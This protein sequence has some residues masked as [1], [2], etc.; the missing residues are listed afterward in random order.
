M[1]KPYSHGD[2]NSRAI[3]AGRGNS[4]LGHSSEPPVKDFD[5]ARKQLTE[6]SRGLREDEQK[7]LANVDINAARPSA[8]KDI[9]MDGSHIGRSHDSR[10]MLSA[11][12]L[13]SS[14]YDMD[15][16]E[17]MDD[18]DPADNIQLFEKEDDKHIK[19]LKVLHAK[20]QAEIRDLRSQVMHIEC[21][22]VI[23]S[24][25]GD[26]LREEGPESV[27]DE[28]DVEPPVDQLIP[29]EN[30]EKET[31][32]LEMD[33]ISQALQA[34]SPPRINTPPIERLPFLTNPPPPFSEI[35]ILQVNAD[36]HQSLKD[37]IQ[38]RIVEQ[39][40]KLAH[41]ESEIM[42]WYQKTYTLWRQNCDKLDQHSK[43]ALP[44][45]TETTRGAELSEAAAL[46]LPID[47]RRGGKFQSELDFQRALRESELDAIE[48]QRKKEQANQE[49]L[50]LAKEAI[51]PPMLNQIQRKA[52]IFQDISNLVPIDDVPGVFEYN[53]PF[54]QFTEEEQEIFTKAYMYDPKRFGAIAEKL[55][56][57]TYPE[58]IRHYYSTKDQER[59]KQKLSKRG[60]RKK[61]RRTVGQGRAK[62][63]N[64][65]MA[66]MRGQGEFDNEEENP[67][68]P[69]TDTGRPKRAAAPVFGD[70]P[71]ETDASAVAQGRRNLSAVRNDHT[72]DTPPERVAKRS[73]TTSTREKSQKRARNPPL[74]AAP[75]PSP[76]KVE[77][78]TEPEPTLE[79]LPRPEEVPWNKDRESAALLTNLQ[80]S[81][82]PLQA[83]SEPVVPAVEERAA[84]APASRI[85]DV[86][87]IAKQS[88]H[89]DTASS[90]YWSVPEQQ[91]FPRLLAYYGT[92]WEEFAEH[93]TSKSAI[94]VSCPR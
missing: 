14:S 16:D 81:S 23:L 88:N 53:A 67:V 39:R 62:T 30:A 25:H 70:V 44:D 15:V 60:G 65:L 10:S 68:L 47:G 75:T 86:T 57:R 7:P 54:R 19:K 33:D 50:D 43:D 4:D 9:E 32:D 38:A 12:T 45:Q 48:Q 37:A 90:S 66:N 52:I 24:R 84:S 11:N 93:M 34:I 58:C 1:G 29:F 42:R 61:G 3:S 72:P 78:V 64:A 89:K 85:Q 82:R 73:K 26:E 22:K 71:V 17:E 63:S 41:E 69:V 2:E 6:S 55:P 8:T 77:K 31:A 35:D 59:Y 40:V 87:K 49:K 18:D 21:V 92:N 79:E 51:I 5:S 13:N 91:D 28:M 46:P 74:V 83:P 80:A 36:L 76:Q 27:K 20:I 94:M 56:G